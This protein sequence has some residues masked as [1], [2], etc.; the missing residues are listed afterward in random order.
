[1]PV[2]CPYDAVIMSGGTGQR[3][4]GRDKAMVHAAGRPLL[5]RAL[6]AV[7]GAS[8]IVVVGPERPVGRAVTFVREDPPGSGPLAGLAAGLTDG[9][10]AGRGAGLAGSGV[11]GA[12]ELVVVLACDLP[13]V[14]QPV[15]DRL[16]ASAALPEHPFH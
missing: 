12:G 5:A 1:R 9:L 8:R 14:D 13:L 6:D 2:G 7:A 3:L 11:A 15:V 16:I 10:G 4:G